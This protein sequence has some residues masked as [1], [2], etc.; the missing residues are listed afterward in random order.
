MTASWRI[1]SSKADSNTWESFT[2]KW[3]EAGVS[4]SRVTMLRHL[5]EK[6]YQATSEPETS[7]EASYLAKENKNW[8]VAQCSKV[9]FSDESTFSF[10]FVNQGLESGWRLERT[11]NLSCLKS[12]VKFP[13][14]VMIWAAVTVCWCWSTVFYQVQ[15]LP[16]DFGALNAIFLLTMILLCILWYYQHAWPEP[17]MEMMGYFQEKDEKQ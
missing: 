16:G 15:S 14:S 5:K 6:S 8:T 3:T 11:H 2:R 17:H 1:L 12:S 7:S 13:Q 9:L 4:A 10:S